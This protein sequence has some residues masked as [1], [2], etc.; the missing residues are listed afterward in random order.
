[1]VGATRATAMFLQG[2][3]STGESQILP[4]LGMKPDEMLGHCIPD[5]PEAEVQGLTL[6]SHHFTFVIWLGVGDEESKRDFR[7]KVMVKGQV[8]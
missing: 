5:M 3:T 8:G 2:E 6:L 4:F 1:M 7:G